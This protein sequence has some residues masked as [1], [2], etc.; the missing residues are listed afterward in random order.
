MIWVEINEIVQSD[1]SQVS[2][3]RGAALKAPKLT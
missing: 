3:G 2:E 1:D